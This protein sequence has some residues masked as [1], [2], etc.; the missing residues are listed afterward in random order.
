MSQIDTTMS[1]KSPTPESLQDPLQGR[2]VDLVPNGHHSSR[3]TISLRNERGLFSREVS[4]GDLVQT[5]DLIEIRGDQVRLLTPNRSPGRTQRWMDRTL[6]PRRLH[7]VETRVQVEAA[8]REYF[9]SQGF[10]ETR[11]PLL[12][13]SPGMET[14][15]RPFQTL[16]GSYLPTSPEFA[17][18]R[19]LAGG[20]EKIFQICPSF[21]LEPNSTT[22]HPEFTML[23]WYRAYADYEQIMADTE[24]LFA[25]VAKKVLGSEEA[26]IQFNGKSIRLSRPW[27]RFKIRDLFRDLA[28]VDL[29][30]SSTPESLAVE[31]RRLGLDPAPED[32]WDDLY[33]RI[34]LNCIEPKLPEDRPCIVMRYPPSQAALSVMD[35][36]PDGTRWAKRFE[37]Y[38]GGLELGNAFQELTDPI[39]QRR[40]FVE[41]MELR[42]RI[43][44]SSFPKS[45]IDEE[46]LHALEEGL[47]PSA[48]IAMGVDRMVMLFAGETDIERTIWL[49]SRA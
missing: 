27:P 43:Y 3:R 30:E 8:I 4:Q 24:N 26:S 19:L 47:P 41:D 36:D 18:K 31:C 45:T 32:T 34:W 49:P 9:L 17:M 14:H 20:L 33:F 37:V 7:G 16:T 25:T 40:R 29:M 10:R 21:R 11:T 6:E 13:P 39:E 38:A 42:E 15:I 1:L 46:F 22:H 28:G 48:G 44:G 2:C 23:E 5:G 35:T 12:V